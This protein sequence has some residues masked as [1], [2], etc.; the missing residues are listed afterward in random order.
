[1]KPNLINF[2]LTPIPKPTSVKRPSTQ[3]ENHELKKQKAS[4]SKGS[5]KPND[6]KRVAISNNFLSLRMNSFLTQRS[7]FLLSAEANHYQTKSQA[8]QIEL[9]SFP[10]FSTRLSKSKQEPNNMPLEDILNPQMHIEESKASTT[11][12]RSP[13]ID[14]SK[15]PSE[16][17]VEFLNPELVKFFSFPVFNRIQTTCL[18]HLLQSTSN[19]IISAP[20][21]TGKT[22]LFEIAIIKTYFPHIFYHVL[23]EAGISEKST[24]NTHQVKAVYVAPIKALC[25]EKIMDWKNKFDKFGLQVLELTGDSDVSDFSEF[26]AANIIITTPEKWDSLTRKW[27]DNKRLISNIALLLLDEVHLLNTE[28]RGAT[29]EAVVTRMKIISRLPELSNTP[30]SALRILAISATIPNIEDI[31]AW[32][33]VPQEHILKFGE[34]LRPIPLEKHVFGYDMNKNIYTFE[35]N[36][37][38]R[39][40]PLIRKYS[41]GKATL[42]FCQTQK[43][44]VQC[45]EQIIADIH[46][47]E[48]IRDSAHELELRRYAEKAQDRNLK[49][50]L[51]HGVAFHNAGLQIEDR[52]LIETLFRTG[53][54]MV[55]CTTTTLAMGVNLPAR[56][57]IIKSTYCYRGPGIGFSE[58]S[59]LE[60]QQMMGRAGRPGFDNRGIVVIM[61]EKNKVRKYESSETGV[62]N[63]ESHLS[64]QLYEHIL[65]E[66]SLGSITSLSQA[67]EYLKGTFFYVRLRLNPENYG[68]ER[69]FTP[70]KLNDYL[71][72]TLKKILLELAEYELIT[73]E[74]RKNG[75][76]HLQVKDLG[77]DITRFYVAF[78]TIKLLY[79]Q[80]LAFRIKEILEIL[81]VAKEFS[82]FRSKNDERKTLVG[83][84]Q[85]LR[86]PLKGAISTPE[87][88]AYVLIQAGI[89]GITIDSFELKR[90]QL[91]VMT[92]CWRILECFKRYFLIKKRGLA[93]INTIKLSKAIS[94]RG[95]ED[96][97]VA[98]LK[99]LH[100]IGDKMAQTLVSNGLKSLQDVAHYDD[101]K[102]EKI[103]NKNHQFV[104]QLKQKVHAIPSYRLCWGDNSALATLE[105]NKNPNLNYE[106]GCSI[107]LALLDRAG[108]LL[109][110]KTVSNYQIIQNSCRVDLPKNV[111]AH[112]YP[113]TAVL[114]Y[115]RYIGMDQQVNVSGPNCH[116]EP[117]RLVLDH[118]LVHNVPQN[119]LL[120][121]VAQMKKNA[122]NSQKAG[123]KGQTQLA[124][125]SRMGKNPLNQLIKKQDSNKGSSEFDENELQL[126]DEMCE[127]KAKEAVNRLQEYAFGSKKESSTEVG[128]LLPNQNQRKVVVANTDIKEQPKAL[129]TSKPR[130]Q[131]KSKK[132]MLSLST[133]GLEKNAI[134]STTTP[135]TCSKE[136]NTCNEQL[137]NSSQ[138]IASNQFLNGRRMQ[139]FIKYR[140]AKALE[141][142]TTAKKSTELDGL[143]DYEKPLK[144][145]NFDD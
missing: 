43:G 84:N 117:A 100:G 120:Q 10:L 51:T 142:L 54:I 87:K 95:W 144:L 34:E 45:C 106:H 44:T 96:S 137:A 93:Y 13:I 30:S 37:N 127:T 113:M 94:K 39:I 63:L 139:A 25:Q 46:K 22:V 130:L 126:I 121:K 114:V 24:E 56:L 79:K 58:Y 71:M 31:A 116:P 70:E 66:I 47:G 131:S 90:N 8:S 104:S 20:T 97:E 72:N 28:E 64:Q 105:H 110:S 48:F 76:E 9:S 7:P 75:T 35:K 88:K 19:L 101:H 83:L 41:S 109:A 57:V 11:S 14:F 49:L 61:T 29:L 60:I 68:L 27:K 91:E 65:A 77:C 62:E 128:R 124:K 133:L 69:N 143:Y 115:E 98:I 107:T 16:I 125:K 108:H 55:I 67:C 59:P 92:I 129:Q 86:Y 123:G 53:V 36:L 141:Q 89:A 50:F 74:K 102:L 134:D 2:H 40:T 112:S 12:Q 85:Q 78:E 6:T 23:S 111:D 33:N 119:T 135:I 52:N 32:L 122:G 26:Q 118:E 21:G 73:Y 3:E 15:L 81:S 80:P 145:Y 140:E 82:R 132:K 42:I 18:P 5:L 103:L 1:M 138:L 17:E 4:T 136:E 99:Q 38:Y